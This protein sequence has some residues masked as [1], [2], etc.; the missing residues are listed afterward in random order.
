M[1]IL[2]WALA[3]PC[4]GQMTP[5]QRL[6]DFEHLAAQYAKFYGPYEWK[7]D[8]IGFD[9]YNIKP[10]LDRVRAAKSD[11][12]YYEAAMEYVASLKD[13]HSSYS[14]PSDF[15]ASIPITVDIFDGKYLIEGVNRVTLPIARYPFTTGD[16]LV[17]IDGK[18]AEELV[19]W[20]MKY[21]SQ[22]NDRAAK[23]LA[24]GRL[25]TRIQSLL[26]RAHELGE[27]ATVV[28]RRQSGEVETYE[29]PWTKRGTPLTANGPLPNVFA[30]RGKAVQPAP[31]V[32][33]TLAR[34]QRREMPLQDS[35]RISGLGS[36]TPFFIL[37]QGFT[38]RLGTLASH[39]HFSGTYTA[40]GKRIGYLRI[41]NFSPPSSTLALTELAAELIFLEQNT[42]GLV[43]DIARN[44]GGG[45]YGET[46][47]R[48]LIARR[49]R[50]ITDEIRPSLSLL[51][52]F[53]IAIAT[54]PPS[55][56]QWQIDQLKNLGAQ[57]ETAYYEN[58]GRTGPLP[59][60]GSSIE[61]D[62]FTDGRGAVVGYTKPILL[63]TDELTTSW[64]DS[65]AHL[66]ADN[67][68]ATLFGNRTNGAGGSIDGYEGGFYAE[69]QT[70]VTVSLGVRPQPVQVPGFPTTAYYENT[71]IWP[72]IPYD[73][74]TA[75]NLRTGYAPYVAAFTS[76]IVDEI[77]KGAR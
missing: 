51:Q 26:P 59:L 54:A 15:V 66:M 57:L 48:L 33:E 56:P 41:P 10:W 2:F 8:V 75:E 64:G 44:T 61:V 62:P 76:A 9:A 67:K 21:R 71:G 72:D 46:A 38:R 13:T 69:A 24:A 3:L 35:E 53:Q 34:I 50:S 49:F 47:A 39:F 43:V 29:I 11:L 65:F 77:N 30:A 32:E 25:F 1:K 42:D 23:R 7:R 12:D 40:A 28:V 16:E 27:N 14:I 45:C 58:R 19:Q 63:L 37:P 17:S 74:M 31:S 73:V 22:S 18:T 4:L 52:S 60:C 55:A 36:R 70:T 6:F 5:E 20:M 68:R